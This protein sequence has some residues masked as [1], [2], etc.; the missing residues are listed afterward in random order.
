MGKIMARLAKCYGCG[1]ELDKEVEISGM[2]TKT[3]YCDTCQKIME[4]E[5]KQ[6][7]PLGYYKFDID[8][9]KTIDDIKLILEVFNLNFVYSKNNQDLFERI[10]HLLIIE[11]K[12][13]GNE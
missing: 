11:E 4:D 2:F 1:K 6:H 8:K 9:I 7:I 10:K 12:N 5:R 3:A 13:N